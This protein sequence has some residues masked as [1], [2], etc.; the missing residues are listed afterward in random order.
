MT[1]PLDTPP[2]DEEKTPDPS[3]RSMRPS[4]LPPAVASAV[5][6]L[7]GTLVAFMTALA[8]V[9]GAY[10][11]YQGSQDTQRATYDT[12]RLQSEQQAL[13]IAALQQGQLE[14]RHWM[15]AI[16]YR[17]ERSSV[18]MPA[19]PEPLSLPSPL[20]TQLPPFESLGKK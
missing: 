8:G 10:Q 16:V 9:V 17:L 19:A 5:G 2:L 20:P 3:V 7:P 18:S 13:Q 1:P 14:L 4:R 12:L 15:E 11:S 6:G